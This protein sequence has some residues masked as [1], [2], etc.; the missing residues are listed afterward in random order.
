M[1]FES[2]W[3]APAS[4][5]QAWPWLHKGLCKNYPPS[6]LHPGPV[7]SETPQVQP[8]HGY[9]SAED[10]RMQPG[11]WTTDLGQMA[12]PQLLSRETG[13][14]PPAT[15]EPPA[16]I[17]EV[18]FATEIGSWKGGGG[19][20]GIKPKDRTLWLECTRQNITNRAQDLMPLAVPFIYNPRDMKTFFQKASESPWNF[21]R[22]KASLI[23]GIVPS[24]SLS[25]SLER[26]YITH[27][28][29][30]QNA[31]SFPEYSEVLPALCL[32]PLPHCHL[33][34][35]DFEPALEKNCSP[36]NHLPMKSG[37]KKNILG[38]PLCARLKL[39]AFKGLIKRC[40]SLWFI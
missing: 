5:S 26:T 37:G 36:S 30:S 16:G 22:R 2:W 40:V 38:V 24:S 33:G 20:V 35:S 13:I 4:S 34:G 11:L 10:S 3:K 14:S 6:G 27:S 1:R 31:G 23:E 28:L 7:M 32:S 12:P 17:C 9:S 19:G 39:K 18:C 8:R 29:R 15:V 21:S 25:S